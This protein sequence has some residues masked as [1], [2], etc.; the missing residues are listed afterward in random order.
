MIKVF[1]INQKKIPHY[2][3]TAY[4]HLSDFLKRENYAFT[5]V[6]EG[7]QEGDIYP[8]KFDH[9]IISLDFINIAK[10]F[11]KERPDVIIYWV[12]L[13][14]L[15][16][17]PML[18]LTKILGKKSIYWGHGTD[19]SGKG[20]MKLKNIAHSTEY[21]LSDAII[22]YANHLKKYIKNQ[23]HKKTFI[24]NNTLNFNSYK[25]KTEVKK[26]TLSKYCITTK[27]N[28]ICMGRMQRRKRIDNLLRAFN[29]INRPD[30]GLIL[31]GPDTEGILKDIQRHNIFKL[32]AIY[33]DE[34]LDILAAADAFCLPGAIGLSIVDAFY[35]GLP[36]VTEAGDVSPETMF[37]KD[38]INGFVVSQGDTKKMAEKLTLLLDDDSL[39]EKFSKA[40]IKEI[41]TNGHI[42][43]MCKG[44]SEALAFVCHNETQ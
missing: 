13:R 37:L 1:L 35:C 3:I 26:D 23:F 20:A 38:G 30:V 2:R 40:A 32:D 12:H 33:G 21:I 18:L 16:L 22:L 19:L 34:R 39:R 42:D 24:A 25:I 44:F 17:F 14:H 28:I 27:K 36:I 31:V 7:V 11:I 10:L 6:S 8:V 5:I 4:N 15:Y 29:L 9:Q 41:H 43:T